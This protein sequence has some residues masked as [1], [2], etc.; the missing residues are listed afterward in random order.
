MNRFEFSLTIAAINRCKISVIVYCIE[1]SRNT[2]K[3]K[4][5]QCLLASICILVSRAV[6]HCNRAVLRANHIHLR[7]RVTANQRRAKHRMA[8]KKKKGESRNNCSG[9]CRNGTLDLKA[10]KYCTRKTSDTAVHRRKHGYSKAHTYNLKVKGPGPGIGCY[11]GL[12]SDFIK[13]R[14]FQR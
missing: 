14:I 7:R 2:N 8:R 9:L 4:G 1:W 11:S 3:S 10:E 5:G 6:A 13:Y 12:T